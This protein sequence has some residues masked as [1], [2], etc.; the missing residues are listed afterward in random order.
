M[1]EQDR[2]CFLPWVRQGLAA[3]IT[4]VDRSPGQAGNARL[5]VR[6]AVN[7]TALTPVGVE[8]QGPAEV[9]GFDPQQV[10]RTDPPASATAFESNCF[11]SIELRRPDFPWLFTP[12][13]ADD[14]GRIR[15]WLCLAVVRR[16]EGVSLGAT[17]NAPAPVLRIAHPARPGEELPDLADCWAWAHAQTSGTADDPQA[18]RQAIGDPA[19]RSLSRLICPR[20]LEP[21]TDYLAAVVP[22]FELGRRAGLGLPIA[23]RDTATLAMAWSSGGAAPKEIELPV[24]YAW[25]FRTGPGGDFASLAARLK[26]G[27]AAGIGTRPLEIGE[28]GFPLPPTLP[29]SIRTR[30]PGALA[31]MAVDADTDRPPPPYRAA[32]AD[33]LARAVPA[34]DGADS[35]PL[36][37]P[38]RYGSVYAGRESLQLDSSG[39]FDA[40]NLDP[41]WR[42]AAALGAR[43]VQNEQERLVAAAWSQAA[44]LL[45]NNRQRARLKLAMAVCES[46]VERHLMA[47]DEDATLRF[48]APAFARLR[49]GGPSDRTLLMAMR[50]SSLP[51]A[52]VGNAM[53]RIARQRGPLARRMA[54][55]GYDRAATPTWTARLRFG[56]IPARSAPPQLRTSLTDLPGREAIAA[57]L[58]HRHFGVAAEGTPLR[59]RPAADLLP[60]AWDYPGHFRAAVVAHLDRLAGP[61][62]PVGASAFGGLRPPM[63]EVAERVRAQMGARVSMVRLALA[64]ATDPAAGDGDRALDERRLTPTL[65]LPLYQGLRNLSPSLLLPGVE[66]LAPDTAIAL[67]T[68]RAF[69]EACL[70]GANDEMARELAWRG[71]PVDPSGTF[72]RDFWDRGAA[73]SHDIGELAGD[74]DRGLGSAGAQESARFVLLLKCEL[75]RRYP[76]AL[77]YLLPAQGDSQPAPAPLNPAFSGS[78]EPD[79][80]FFGFPIDPRVATGADGG[81]GYYAVIEE[82]PTAPRFGLD[83]GILPEGLRH[84]RID[85][86]PSGL[87]PGPFVW[88]RNSAHMAC[89]ARREPVRVLI[90]ASH[91]MTLAPSTDSSELPE[92]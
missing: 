81:P 67:E 9:Q 45:R 84:L 16:Q 65:P 83:A 91:L 7:D 48:A 92:A 13:R 21:E 43:V 8:L 29:A 58:W 63:P 51:V 28:P 3:G 88:G 55:Q 89:I 42:V 71:F 52:A 23:A 72:L 78:V 66:R 31:P 4:T 20:V 85:G 90:H 27:G 22:T 10:L 1:T 6:L 87:P 53:R 47:L 26:A 77:L 18:V 37:A 80:A 25:G 75:L 73:G 49:A 59:P 19:G 32:L 50:D 5:Q 15:P 70:V 40:L 57:N 69:A 41:R 46:L 60:A 64:I 86:P 33:L 17:P 54:A 61:Q 36:L 24:Y 62:S 30:L 38:P 56:D 11:A 14:A 74:P 79:I 39:W 82:H 44:E 68:N 34:G 35:E 2:L 76:D 12:A